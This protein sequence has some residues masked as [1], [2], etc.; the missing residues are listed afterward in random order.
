MA[1]CGQQ[2]WRKVVVEIIER[3]SAIGCKG[4]AAH[5]F[6]HALD[7]ARAN[8]GIHFRNLLHDFNAVA[9]DQAAGHN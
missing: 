5:R 4:L 2:A 6:E 9:L 8:H 1:R 3:V 7:F